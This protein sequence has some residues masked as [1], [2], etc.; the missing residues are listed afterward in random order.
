[1]AEQM[2][3]PLAGEIPMDPEMVNMG[4]KGRLDLLSENSDLDINTAYE[5]VVA[6][7]ENEK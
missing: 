3:V 6:F 2:G 5:E 7:V 4:D 1:M